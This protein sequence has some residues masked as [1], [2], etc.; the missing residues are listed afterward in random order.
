MFNSHASSA[1]RSKHEGA[2]LRSRVSEIREIQR[3]ALAKVEPLI[4]E[5]PSLRELA[6]AVDRTTSEHL[7]LALLWRELSSGGCKITDCFFTA[8]R[9]FLLTNANLGQVTRPRPMQRRILEAVLVSGAQKVVAMELGLAASTVASNAQQALKM[10]GADCKPSR[11]HPLL[12][13][14]ARAACS[15]DSSATGALSFVAWGG[16]TLRIVSISRPDRHLSEYVSGAELSVL[17]RLVEGECY[18]TI[19]RQR[20]TSQRTVANQIAS[21]FR[22]LHVSGR[23]ELLLRLFT[24]E[25]AAHCP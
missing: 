24:L 17:K 9:C 5:P 13:L 12:V 18:E 21:V 4:E 20:G 14:A 16:T 11:P 23:A 2:E 10:L 1:A 25:A 19:A 22:R 3:P 15:G 8:E 6:R 7:S